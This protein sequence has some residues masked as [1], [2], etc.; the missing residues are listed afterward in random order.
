M[1]LRAVSEGRRTDPAT[2]RTITWHTLL[3]LWFIVALTCATASSLAAE[4]LTIGQLQKYNASYHMHSVTIVGKVE[5]MDALPPLLL[6]RGRN[7]PL[8][9]I[10]YGV[11]T[12]VLVDDSGSL[13][14]ENPGSCFSAAMDL[15][16]DGDH[17]EVTVMIHIQVPEGQTSQV[18]KGIIQDIV[19][20]K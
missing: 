7:R 16:H 11:A 17:I 10:R 8:C 12:F 19:V 18:I 3:P 6:K 15:P 9:N 20:L 5:A 1:R 13:P 14:V 2:V 4:R